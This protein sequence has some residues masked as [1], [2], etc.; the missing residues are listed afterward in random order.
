MTASN[1]FIW[2]V[3]S[4][5]TL[6]KSDMNGQHTQIGPDGIMESVEFIAAMDGY[7][8]VVENGTLYRTKG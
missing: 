5:G 1:G 8:Y 6:F 7:L 3:E 4:D 2:S